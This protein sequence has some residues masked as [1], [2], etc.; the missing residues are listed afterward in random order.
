M[1]VINPATGKE[2]R[3]ARNKWTPRTR[4]RWHKKTVDGHPVIGTVRDIAHLDWM[5][6]RA[7][8]TFGH[9]L[10]VLQSAFHTG[11]KASEGT[12]DFGAVYDLWIP[13]V[14]PWRQQQFFRAHGF[15]CWYRHPP[16][17]GVHIHGI[18]MVPYSGDPSKAFANHG[19][20]VGVYID[21][22]WSL[23]GRKVASS[24]VE[25][26]VDRAFALADQ[27]FPNSD[28]SWHPGDLH[29]TLFDLHAYV[30]R[31]ARHQAAA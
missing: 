24:Q 27:H 29:A 4:A 10:T 17:F 19:F 2:F 7:I 30:Q 8:A 22:G 5:N 16:L 1:T 14:D 18:C 15:W 23:Y 6:R 20:K 21:G 3:W 25:D 9:G 26:Y 11:V 13:G 28:R 31:R 12:H